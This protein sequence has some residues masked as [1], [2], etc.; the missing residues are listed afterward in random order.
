MTDWVVQN[1]QLKLLWNSEEDLIEFINSVIKPN[2]DMLGL[3]ITITKKGAV[4]KKIV[5]P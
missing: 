2:A 1:G 3:E 4:K 5:R